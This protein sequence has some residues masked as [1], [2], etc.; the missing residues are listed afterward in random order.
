MAGKMIKRTKIQ[1]LSSLATSL[2]AD[3]KECGLTQI[4]PATGQNFTPASGAGKFVLESSA[5]VNPLHATQPWRLV[6]DLKGANA[7]AGSI[8][9]AIANPQQIDNSGTVAKFPFNV[10][11]TDNTMGQIGKSFSAPGKAGDV[12]IDRSLSVNPYDAGTTVSYIMTATA[13]GLGLFV[14]EEGTDTKPKFSWF[15]VQ[16]PVDKDTGDALLTDNSPIF[17]VFSCD[18]AS[19]LKYV[20]SESDVSRPTPA[21]PADVDGLNYTAIM[22][23]KEQVAIAKGNKYLITFPNRL[24]TDRYAYTEE[25]D[26][27]AYT[28]ADVIAD[29]SEIPITVYGE[30]TPRIYRAMKANG[31]D[32][33][34]MRIMMLVSGGGIDAAV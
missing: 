31:P 29:E 11:G 17:C 34:G 3:F 30:A 6:L 18:N 15:F 19:P 9:M 13:R 14:W 16:S 20:V 25:L 33:T 8:A 4:M 1:S 5:A 23:T 27:F 12:F 26:L 21:V 24:N 32:N 10:T 2:F 28:S 7:Y 22:N